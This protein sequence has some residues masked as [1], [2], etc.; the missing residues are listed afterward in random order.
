MCL[1]RPIVRFERFR[2]KCQTFL[3]FSQLTQFRMKLFE[4]LGGR[5]DWAYAPLYNAV[6]SSSA[7]QSILSVDIVFYISGK[8]NRISFLATAAADAIVRIRAF[9]SVDA[10]VKHNTPQIWG[11][12]G[13]GERKLK[14]TRWESINF[15]AIF[16][17]AFTS[18]LMRK[19]C[20]H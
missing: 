17:E 6:R 9:D 16:P 3:F 18:V 1:Y 5:G 14:V 13:N 10:S 19:P 12:K 20:A 7:K 15:D 2:Q 11:S 8:Y 4:F